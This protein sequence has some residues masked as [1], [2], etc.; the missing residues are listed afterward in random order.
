MKAGGKPFALF[1]TCLMLVSR[2]ASFSILNME[3]T[4]PSETSVDFQQTTLRYIPDNITF[5]K[6][7]CENLKLL[8]AV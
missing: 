8:L 6:H 2:L 7:S 3:A 4:P 1:A 5:H